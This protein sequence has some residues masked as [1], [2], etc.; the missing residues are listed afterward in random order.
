MSVGTTLGAFGVAQ[1]L[2][3]LKEVPPG[4][5][6]A[7][8]AVSTDLS[9]VTKHFRRSENSRSGAL[10]M[11]EGRSQPPSPCKVYK[12]LG[13]VLGTVDE[14]GY[15]ALQRHPAVRTVKEAPELSLIRP[16]AA[17][18]V[19]PAK[20]TTWGITRLQVD[21]L[22]AMG[23]TGEGVLVGHLDTGVDGKHAALK[24]AIAKFAEFD[25]MGEQVAGATAHDSDEHGTHTA[26]TIVGRAVKGSKFGVAP[27][28]KLA[29]GIVIEGGNVIARILGGMDWVVGEGVKILSMSL[30]LRGFRQE[31]LPLMQAIRNRGI[32]PVMAVGNE[33]PGTSRSPGNYD[34]VLSVGA[35]DEAD[36]VA[37]FSSSQKFVRKADPIVPD[38]VAP[39]VGVLSAL[40]GGRFGKMNGSSMATP[41]IA[42]LAAVLWQ[43]KPGATVDE[44]EAA[45]FGSCKL[46]RSMS[47]SRANRGIPNA[48]AAHARLMAGVSAGIAK[49]KTKKVQRKKIQKK[50]VQKK[51]TVGRK[52]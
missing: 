21:K 22:W 39:G 6:A 45:I 37:D 33:G 18:E 36:K 31:F 49:K 10:A 42:G 20:G 17:A 34:I 51:K 3:T 50:Q 30:G 52:K 25:A 4:D 44:I 5:T 2:V 14:K 11:A 29:S 9:S 48:V 32:L 27:G 24:G 12:N 41:H 23:L 1:V 40:P 7:L 15:K 46:P 13:L 43:A 16:V 35:G 26:G 19:G 8:S 47:Q 38:V 28:A